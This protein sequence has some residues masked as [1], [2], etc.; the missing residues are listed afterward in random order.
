MHDLVDCEFQATFSD[1]IYV[2]C[3]RLFIV[4]SRFIDLTSLRL[5]YNLVNLSLIGTLTCVT[6]SLVGY[7]R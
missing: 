1:T 7:Y 4:W 3:A 2:V 6:S 5:C